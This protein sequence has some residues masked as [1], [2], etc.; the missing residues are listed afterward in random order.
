MNEVTSEVAAISERTRVALMT[1]RS[2]RPAAAEV[3]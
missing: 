3:K 1:R 2:V